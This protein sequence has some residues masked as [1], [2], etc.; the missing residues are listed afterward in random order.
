MSISPSG[1]RLQGDDYQHLFA[2]YQILRLLDLRDDIIGVSVEAPDVDLLDDVVLRRH[3]GACIYHQIKFSVNA[4]RPID[5]DFWV[6]LNGQKH[7]VLARLWEAFKGLRDSQIAPEL[8]LYTNRP[9]D[10]THPILQL[11]DGHDGHIGRTLREK[12]PGSDARKKCREWANRIGIVEADLLSLLDHLVL[13]T[14][15]GPGTSL[16]EAVRDRMASCGLQN[17]ANA[18]LLG[19][20]AVRTWVKGGVRHVDVNLLRA[21]IAE[22]QLQAMPP[23]STLMVEAIDHLAWPDRAQASVDWVDLFVGEAPEDRRQLRDPTLWNSRLAPEMRTACR[24]VEACLS[25]EPPRQVRVRGH[26]RLT[27]AFLVGKYLPTTRGIVLVCEQSGAIW[28]TDAAPIDSELCVELDEFDAGRDLVVAL[29]VARNIKVDVRNF[30]TRVRLPVGRF[31]HIHTPEI[32]Q[33]VPDAGHA[34][35]LA[36]AVRGLVEDQAR[37]TRPEKVHLFLGTPL[38]AAMFLGHI[39]NAMPQVQLYEQA[40]VGGYLPSFLL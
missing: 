11:R 20:A 14:D 32:P 36:L 26:M 22:R 1:A 25:A 35:G 6:H 37:A 30:V 12:P 4:G 24:R 8:V 21:A 7:S 28:R 17:D 27:P 18:L 16:E 23:M 9:I 38:A 15:V 10:P 34:R 39:W 13:R 2:W 5:D 33:L 19:L 29:S 31:L 3:N 40:A